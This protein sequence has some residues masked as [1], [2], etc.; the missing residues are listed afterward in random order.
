LV[1]YAYARVDSNFTLYPFQS[2]LQHIY[3]G[4]PYARVDLNPLPESAQSPS[5]GLRIWPQGILS[6]EDRLPHAAAVTCMPIAHSLTEF[7]HNLAT[8]L[9]WEVHKYNVTVYLLF[10]NPGS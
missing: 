4:Q 10:D 8:P 2:R 3:H 5:Q 7:L 9:K 6:L 1:P